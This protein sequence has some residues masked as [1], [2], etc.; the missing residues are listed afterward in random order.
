LDK[1]DGVIPELVYIDNNRRVRVLTEIGDGGS[2]STEPSAGKTEF[3][4]WGNN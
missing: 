4:F 2:C 3:P 1:Q